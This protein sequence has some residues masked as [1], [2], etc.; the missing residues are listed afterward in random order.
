MSTISLPPRREAIVQANGQVSPVWLRWFNDVLQRLGGGEV[1]TDLA[2]IVAL[3]TEAGAE[4]DELQSEYAPEPVAVREAL[5]A[6]EELRGELASV[7]MANDELRGQIED[8]HRQM[9]QSRGEDLR[10][11]IETIEGRLG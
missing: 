9:Q 2:A 5:R 3:L 6:V 7:R 11:R 8:L 4:I 1:D 10:N